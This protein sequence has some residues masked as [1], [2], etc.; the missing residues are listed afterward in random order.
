MLSAD[1]MP[2]DFFEKVK[3]ELN[4]TWHDPDTEAKILDK[5]L[6]AEI[7]LNHKLGAEIDYLK[8]GQERQLF[9]A[10]MLYVWNGCQNEFDKA[11]K[12]EIYQIRHKYEVK[13]AKSNDNA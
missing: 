13:G 1:K 10:Y 6:D 2:R 12:D 5:I 4:I 9:F 8:P 7:T 3:R 11:Y